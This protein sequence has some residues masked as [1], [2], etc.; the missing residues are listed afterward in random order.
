VKQINLFGLNVTASDTFSVSSIFALNILQEKFGKNDANKAVNISLVF[1]CL[2]LILSQLHLLYA[3]IDVD[4]T[5]NSFK[6]IFNHSPRIIIS[7][8]AIFYLSQ[9]IDL[10][11]FSWLQ[12]K[13]LDKWLSFRIITATLLSQLFDT[14]GFSFIALFGIV[15]T[16]FD[17]ILF[18]TVIKCI[19]VFVC[20]ILLK[21]W[22]KKYG[23]I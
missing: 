22:M 18:S 14:C 23:R 3:P 9:K 4:T 10:L 19:S 15:N 7:S 20:S 13:F 5:H 17:I 1:L 6:I 11:I 21:M 12:N 2:F 8:I 16:I